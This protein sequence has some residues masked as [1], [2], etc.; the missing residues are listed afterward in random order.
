MYYSPRFLKVA[1]YIADTLRGYK[2]GDPIEAHRVQYFL[3][4]SDP[5]KSAPN[6]E[7]GGHLPDL[8]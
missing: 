1:G 8:G 6:P 5:Y 4:N 2:P 7:V 3:D